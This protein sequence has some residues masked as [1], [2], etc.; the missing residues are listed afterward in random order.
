MRV[1][2]YEYFGHYFEGLVEAVS[3]SKEN[4]LIKLAKTLTV[5]TVAPAVSFILISGFNNN[6]LS[7]S[8]TIGSIAFLLLLYFI[9]IKTLLTP[10][11]MTYI[12]LLPEKTDDNEEIF[13]DQISFAKL[14]NEA[15]CGLAIATDAQEKLNNSNSLSVSDIAYCGETKHYI[16]DSL[17][18]MVLTSSTYNGKGRIG[19]ILIYRFRNAL[20]VCEEALEKLKNLNEKS[21]L[22]YTFLNEENAI[23]VIKENLKRT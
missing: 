10:N 21:D 3:S 9:F 6:D 13:L 17:N 11:I 2:Q 4:D 8:S 23:Q 22:G 12:G 7:F 16:G 15:A 18:T 5:A 19:N 1:V 20:D 14:L